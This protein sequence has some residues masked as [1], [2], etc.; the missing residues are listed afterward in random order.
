MI[1]R[2]AKTNFNDQPVRF[3]KIVALTFL[4]LTIV[5]FGIIVFMSSKRAVITITTKP[6]PVEASI[7][8]GN[9]DENQ[10]LGIAFATTTVAL[11]ETFKPT[12]AGSGQGQGHFI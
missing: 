1:S 10:N 6:S 11:E 8:V 9:T 5:L 3:Y 2:R 4:L 7:I 12:G